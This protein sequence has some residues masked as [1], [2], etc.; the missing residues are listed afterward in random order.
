MTS[1]SSTTVNLQE[2]IAETDDA[3]TLIVCSL[4]R[5]I[6][7]SKL[8]LQLLLELSENDL[9]RNAIGSS[10]GCMLLLVSILGSDDPQAANDAKQ[11][12]ENLSFLHENIV[13]MAKAN[14]FGPLLHLLSSGK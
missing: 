14:Y 3:I 7:E 11:L 13:Q 5:K 9:A 12:L 1:S 6:E 2:S 10:Q 8:A 4:A